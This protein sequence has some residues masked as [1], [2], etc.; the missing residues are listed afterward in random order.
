MAADASIFESTGS[1][2]IW[3]PAL[4]ALAGA[5]V[6][7]LGGVVTQLV[8]GAAERRRERMRL[9]IQLAVADH[10]SNIKR[11]EA[12][13]QHGKQVRIFPVGLYVDFHTRF[14]EM[15]D[16]GNVTPDAVRKTYE[17]NR[18]VKAAIETMAPYF[19]P[20]RSAEEP[21]AD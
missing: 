18:A 10:D 12:W 3:V 14:L 6:G 8:Q 16:R 17:D 20:K 7:S 13:A 1:L 15:I 11:A 5:L 2:S 4:S 19:V 9:A 21:G